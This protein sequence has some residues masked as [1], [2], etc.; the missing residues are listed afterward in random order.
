V[1]PKGIDP[2]QSRAAP[3]EPSVAARTSFAGLPELIL[4]RDWL[5]D[6]IIVFPR[7]I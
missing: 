5:A 1:K 2:P 4:A 6:P 7:R 3:S